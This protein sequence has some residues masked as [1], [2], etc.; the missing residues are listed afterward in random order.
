ME[1][2]R[3]REPSGDESLATPFAFGLVG[4]G[5]LCERAAGAGLLN[6][7]GGAFGFGD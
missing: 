1:T 6:R 5:G 4:L 7:E 3:D 2:G